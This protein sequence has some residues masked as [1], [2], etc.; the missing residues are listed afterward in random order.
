MWTAAAASSLYVKSSRAQPQ[1]T[2]A[3]NSRVGSSAAENCTQSESVYVFERNNLHVLNFKGGLS[4]ADNLA[5]FKSRLSRGRKLFSIQEPA[6]IQQ[7]IALN[8]LS[9]FTGPAHPQQIILQ[10]SRIGSFAADNVS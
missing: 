9:A 5:Q 8:G 7:K 2:V 10:N 6:D 1:C 3:L 4:A